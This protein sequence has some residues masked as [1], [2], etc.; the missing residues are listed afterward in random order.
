LTSPVTS[1]PRIPRLTA[2]VDINAVD[3]MLVFCAVVVIDVTSLSTVG[4]L[5]LSGVVVVAPANMSAVEA[6]MGMKL[7]GYK[8]ARVGLSMGCVFGS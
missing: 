3:V 2:A 4:V 1:Q 5:T 7:I 8:G 6:N